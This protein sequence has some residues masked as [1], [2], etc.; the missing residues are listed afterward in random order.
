MCPR[1]EGRGS[2]TDM[3]LTRLY[4]ASKSLADGAL[5]A[6]GYKAGGWNARLYTESGL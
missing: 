1:R 5:L 3:D 6:P 4:D 2:V